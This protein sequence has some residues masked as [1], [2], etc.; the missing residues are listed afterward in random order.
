MR[1]QADSTYGGF[2]LVE[3]LATVAA[4]IIVLGL[5]VSLARYVR[6]R[7]ADQLTKQLLAQLD[8]LAAAYHSH[9][10]AWPAV[11]PFI[12]PG[13]TLPA[14][15]GGDWTGQV[16]AP[17]PDEA[18]LQRTA[19]QNNGD[20]VTRLRRLA[21]SHPSRKLGEL[22]VSLYDEVH[23]LDAW[24]RPIVFMPAMHPPFGPAPNNH[25]FFL[26]AGP[27]GRFTTL[28]DNIYSYERPEEDPT[29]DLG[30]EPGAAPA[31]AG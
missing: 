18:V 22:P 11:S 1:R 16:E 8:T 23:L 2:T 31:G 26:S 9:F 27:D 21:E 14:A 13:T 20:L 10:Q 29:Q 7:A 30:P 4:L 24:G 6:G 17:L 19:R 25:P 3:M 28:L 5:M 12:P 15:A